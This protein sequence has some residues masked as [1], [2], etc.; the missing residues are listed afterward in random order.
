MKVTL[1]VFFLVFLVMQAFQIDKTN[2]T[3]EKSLEIQ[4]PKEVMTIFK[5]ACFDCHSNNTVWPWYS[6]IAPMSWTVK[7]HVEDGRRALNL[8]LWNSLS[9]EEQEKKLK[10]I[11]KKVY[12][13]MPLASYIALHEEADLTKEERSLIREWTGVRR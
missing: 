13:A 4:A 1:I 6:N 7:N 11:Y 5:K 12:A 10:K 3:S 8:S 2:P 9:K